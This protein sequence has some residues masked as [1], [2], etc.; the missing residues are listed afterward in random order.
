MKVL[1]TKFM[2]GFIKMADDGFRL[3]WHERNGGN[4]SYRM[5]RH[6]VES[7]EE[8]LND[9]APWTPIGAHVPGLA[10]EYF[11]V[12]GSGKFFRNVPVDPEACLCII[13]VD[14]TGENYRIRWGLVEGGRPTSELPSH[15]MNHEVKKKTTNGQHRVIYHAHP[16]NTIALTFVLPLTDEVF[17]RELWEMATECPVVFPEG[18]GV[19]GWMVP[20]GEA[21]GIETSKKMQD[22]NAAI[23]AHHGVFCSGTTFDETFGLMH[24]VEKSAEILCKVLAMTPNKLNTIQ[25][26]EFRELAKDF[27]VELPEKF[28]YEK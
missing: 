7:V 5:T 4:L 16:T 2:Q 23:W 18:V 28:L 11:L 1:D 19:I 14:E 10:G 3:G 8:R 9:Q 12:T 26:D 15:L 22:Y 6:E 27:H 21:I 17:T 24:T 25:P 13:E 20:G